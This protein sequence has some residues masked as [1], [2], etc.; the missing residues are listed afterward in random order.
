M[1]LLLAKLGNMCILIIFS[2]VCDV[3]N[4]EIN[5]SFLIKPFFYITKTSRQKFKYPK[6][7]KSHEK[8]KQKN[9]SINFKEFSVVRNFTWHES[10]IL[11]ERASLWM[12]FKSLRSIL[13]L[14]QLG[15]KNWI[16]KPSALMV[17]SK[18]CW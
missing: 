6:S 17:S 7:E 9:F 13:Q 11:R 2:P 5:L 4:L 8:K 12:Q 10:E 18:V 15:N 1:S 14:P 16:T 3:I